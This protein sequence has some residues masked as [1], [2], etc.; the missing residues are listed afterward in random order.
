M[1]AERGEMKVT[2]VSSQVSPAPAAPTAGPAVSSTGSAFA[3]TLQAQGALPQHVAEGLLLDAQPAMYRPVTTLK[4]Q[5]HPAEL[6][7]VDVKLVGSGDQ[8][9][10]EV[11]VENSEARHR[12]T[13]DSEA[14]VKALRGMGYDIDRITIQP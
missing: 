3:T 1:A 9:S 4:I 5:L 2:V 13:T 6:G 10:I 11:Q 7:M 12:L 14:I 8:L